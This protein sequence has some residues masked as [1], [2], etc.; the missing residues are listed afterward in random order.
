MVTPTSAGNNNLP[1]GS[2][3]TEEDFSSSFNAFQFQTKRGGSTMFH[4][5]AIR[6]HIIDQGFHR[7]NQTTVRNI[8]QVHQQELVNSE[9]LTPTDP[10][11]LQKKRDAPDEPSHNSLVPINKR[12]KTT[13][14]ANFNSPPNPHVKE[15]HQKILSGTFVSDLLM[16]AVEKACLEIRQVIAKQELVNATESALITFYNQIHSI[17][18]GKMLGSFTTDE[19]GIIRGNDE[20]VPKPREIEELRRKHN[21]E[22]KELEHQH[23]AEIISLQQD[24][25]KQ[26]L[27]ILN[28]HKEE[29]REQKDRYD[30]KFLNYLDST[31]ESLRIVRGS[32]F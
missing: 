23:R 30:K 17:H 18:S 7:N 5:G 29:I 13:D 12:M 9:S 16:K 21:D 22:K 19:N 32:K 31:S 28:Q 14:A 11:T 1:V 25:E 27:V 4:A 2:K 26:L 20:S 8:P 24:H 15:N 6:R 10:V 3:A